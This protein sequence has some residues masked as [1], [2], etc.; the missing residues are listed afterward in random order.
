MP[1]L[2]Y[3]HVMVI[4]VAPCAALA[5][6][7]YE[8]T[9]LEQ[10]LDSAF[11]YY[12][13]PQKGS[14]LAF[15][16]DVSI[17]RFEKKIHFDRQTFPQDFSIELLGKYRDPIQL[18][19]PGWIA[20]LAINFKPLGINYFFEQ[21]Y[22]QLAPNTFQALELP[23]WQKIAM[24][25][26]K[27]HEVKAQVAILERFLLRRIRSNRIEEL[28]S[29]EQATTLL[30]S[31]DRDWSIADIASHVGLN[32]KTLVRRFKKFA[33]CS[34]LQLKRILRFRRSID[35]KQVGATVQNLTQTALESEFYDSSHFGREYRLLTGHSP[36]NFFK[37]VSF[38][39]ESRYPY[40]FV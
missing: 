13:F 17:Q 19:Y 8:Y 25:L 4:E 38:Q 11:S 14:S 12:V 30:E 26:F 9:A 33:G 39:K 37:E 21:N 16:K 32:E 10:H 22:Q 24:S 2:S 1:Q 7:V 18:S 5:P 35:L 3:I 27:E 36:K 34:P 28:A 20:E 40:R 29:L 6:Y 31:T 15:F 23:E